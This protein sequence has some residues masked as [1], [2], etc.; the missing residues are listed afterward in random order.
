MSLSYSI[1]LSPRFPL[2]ETREDE[3]IASGKK[4]VYVAVLRYKCN[5]MY[6]ALWSYN[7]IYNIMYGMMT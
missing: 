5:Q 4:D 6:M 3:A 1:L 2:E 7:A